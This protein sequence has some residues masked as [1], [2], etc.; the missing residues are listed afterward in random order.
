MARFWSD[1]RFTISAPTS[2]GRR[3]VPGASQPRLTFDG[4]MLAEVR[5]VFRRCS[6]T[7]AWRRSRP[8]Q[9]S[10]QTPWV[11]GSTLPVAPAKGARL[12]PNT[13]RSRSVV[14]LLA[15]LAVGLPAAGGSQVPDSQIAVFGLTDADIQA[16]IYVG[17]ST[18]DWFAFRGVTTAGRRYFGH[19][20]YI[21]IVQGPF[22]RLASA[23]ATSTRNGQAF[24][25]DSVTNEMRAPLLVIEARPLQYE[26][27]GDSLQ[28]V[29]PATLIL[30]LTE[31]LEGRAASGP[32]RYRVL[33]ARERD[34]R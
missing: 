6:D 15:T 27:L 33:P 18:K 4:P 14:A 10:T 22:G 11:T 32:G 2:G 13:A 31:Q 3:T 20:E 26:S 30:L 16:A 5:S 1:R 29:A 23:V 34:R 9:H 25:P 19:V 28:I 8:I 12:T 7:S 24:T 21:L 17:R